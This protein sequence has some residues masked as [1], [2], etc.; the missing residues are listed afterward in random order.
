MLIRAVSCHRRHTRY[1]HHIVIQGALDSVLG[2]VYWTPRVRTVHSEMKMLWHP[3]HN[4]DVR[5]NITGKVMLL[6]NNGTMHAKAQRLDYQPMV[7]SA[8]HYS[9]IAE[10]GD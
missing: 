10:E 5:I 4:R 9:M 6:H 2:A 8:V 1:I 7:C 3:W